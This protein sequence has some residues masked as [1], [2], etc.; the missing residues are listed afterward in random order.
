MINRN[1][2][3]YQIGNSQTIGRREVQS[4][5]FA[6]R[7]NNADELFAVL[8]DGTIDHPNGRRAAIIAVEYCVNAFTRNVFN[9]HT[10]LT[11]LEIALRVNKL[12]QNAVFVGKSPRLSLAMALFTSDEVQYFNVGVNRIFLYDGFNERALGGDNANPYQS[13]TCALPKGNTIGVMSAGAHAIT[14]PMERIRV[15]ESQKDVFDKAQAMVE[16]AKKKRLNDQAN[17]TALL[18]EVVK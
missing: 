12:I 1:N 18:V 15:I 3:R 6:T 11:M 13:G 4:N 7:H 17:A 10:G 9:R 14:H 2:S 5:Y 8:A 16:F